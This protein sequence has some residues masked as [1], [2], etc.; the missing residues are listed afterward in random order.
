LFNTSIFKNIRFGLGDAA[1][2]LTVDE[3]R[4]QVVSAAKMANAHQFIESLPT[5]YETKVGEKGIQLSGGQRQRIAIARALIKNPA[6]LLLDEATSALDAKAEAAVQ[7]AL[8]SASC[9]RTTITIAHRLSTIYRAHNIIVMCKGRIV[10]QGQHD[11]LLRRGGLYTS[12]VQAQSHHDSLQPS[13]DR[14]GS[15]VVDGE[16]K[17]SKETLS[18]SPEVLNGPE[19]PSDD[20]NLVS[21]MA[22]RDDGSRVTSYQA[23]NQQ[24]PSLWA[25]LRFMEKLNR[26]ER[27]FLVSG[28]LCAIVAGFGIPVYV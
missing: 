21:G 12:L 11:A 13:N 15:D 4:E 7:C 9:G 18:G 23:Q 17:K 26:P 20:S 24:I 28:L 14:H 2:Q 1:C 22:P 3:V 10:E 8:D 19:T 6:I 5:G 16:S 27:S 25:T